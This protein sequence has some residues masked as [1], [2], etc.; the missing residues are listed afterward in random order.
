MFNC[1]CRSV[2]F[3]KIKINNKNILQKCHFI[4]MFHDS[5]NILKSLSKF[6]NSIEIFLCILL[7][8]FSNRSLSS[9]IVGQI[10][11]FKNYLMS[12]VRNILEVSYDYPLY[13]NKELRKIISLYIIVNNFSLKAK[14]LWKHFLCILFLSM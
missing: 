11:V 9:S 12:Y 10:T 8:D 7:T 4:W 2:T 5:L 14:F 3:V 6:V 1:N 13:G